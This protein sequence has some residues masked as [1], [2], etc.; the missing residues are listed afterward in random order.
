MR[1]RHLVNRRILLESGVINQDV[2]SAELIAHG[3]EHLGDIIFI[4][5]VGT[6]SERSVAVTAQFIDHGLRFVFAGDIIDADTRAGMTKRKGDGPTYAGAGTSDDCLLSLQ[7]FAMFGFGHDRLWQVDE[8]LG[9]RHFRL[10]AVCGCL[11]W[12]RIFWFCTFVATE[13]DSLQN[14]LVESW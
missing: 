11:G 2:D 3:L 8:T 4:R 9:M 7:Q 5:N 1:K 6:I 10:R 14:I 13:C 12:H